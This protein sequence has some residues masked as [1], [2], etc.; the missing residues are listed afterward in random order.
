[1]VS[2]FSPPGARPIVDHAFYPPVSVVRTMADLLVVPPLNN[3][4]AMA[5]PLGIL[6]VSGGQAPFSED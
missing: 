1:M 2:K 5:P 3:K 4:Y 6:D